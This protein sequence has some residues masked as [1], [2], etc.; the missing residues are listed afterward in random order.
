MKNISEVLIHFDYTQ[1][2]RSKQ[3]LT[4]FFNR[5]NHSL[6]Q[7]LEVQDTLKLFLE[8]ISIIQNYKINDQTVSSVHKF[9]DET[10]SR[11]YTHLT[12]LTYREFYKEINFNISLFI[13][14]FYRLGL[15]LRNL[16]LKNF[17]AE[18]AGEIGKTIQFINSLSVN[19]HYGK[20]LNFKQRK[21]ILIK[22]ESEK[23][24]G[25]FTSFWDFFYR[26]DMYSAI[27]K[28]IRK[29]DLVFPHFN[30]EN[31]FTING[32]YHLNLADSVKNSVNITGNNTVIFT[33]ANM[34]GK[35]TAM[36]SISIVV[37]LAHL[38]LAVPATYC[39]IPFY[40]SIFLFFS[41]NDDLEKGYSYF[42]R[43][44][45]NLKEVLLELKSKNCFAVFDE[46]F[47]GTNINDAAQITIRTV[48]GLS[49]YK[50][51]MFILST[52]LNLI[53]KDLAENENILVLNLESFVKDEQLLFTYR[54]K[55]GWSK[56]EIG[57][58][59]FDKYGL[60]ALLR[61]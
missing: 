5:K 11:H 13:E 26:F 12:S 43:E 28:G 25:N 7:A 56:I 32:F 38:G 20:E 46:I 59:L 40:D 50:N 55:E 58:I 45:I 42:A 48:E 18:Y 39:N 31:T 44:I 4:S 23:E 54:L 21:S 57:R 41:V 60:N 16:N 9:L 27:A 35:S 15:L 34:S 49:R 29:F 37:L 47:K 3:Y 53:E 19:E 36:K 30:S 8:N 14:F 6:E 10:E 51:S 33:G 22:I 24:S 2:R 61:N 52:H 1:T 17:N